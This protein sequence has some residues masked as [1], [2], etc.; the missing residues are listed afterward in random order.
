MWFEEVRGAETHIA[1]GAKGGLGDA[2]TKY[3][4]ASGLASFR[5]IYGDLRKVQG[6]P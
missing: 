2:M 5:K 3:Q 1:D 4:G 6:V